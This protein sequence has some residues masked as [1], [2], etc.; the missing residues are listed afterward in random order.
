MHRLLG[1]IRLH[2]GNVPELPLPVL[3]HERPFVTGVF[4]EGVPRRLA[5]VGALVVSLPGVFRRYPHV[6]K[7]ESKSVALGKPKDGFVAPRETI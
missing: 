1:M 3:F 5:T 6:I 2:V 4:A 7:V